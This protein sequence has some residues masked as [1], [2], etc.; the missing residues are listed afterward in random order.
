MTRHRLTALV[1]AA[2]VV[3]VALGFVLVLS[4]DR[5]TAPFGDSDEGVNAAVWATDSRAVRELGITESRLGGLRVDGTLYASH[6]PLIVV[7]TALA[8]TVFG[9]HEWASRMPAWAGT[10]GALVAMFALLRRT[11]VDAVASAGAVAAVAVT[12]MCFTYGSMLDTPVT[13]LPFG[14]LL[15]VAWQ[16]SWT[17]MSSSDGGGPAPWM[18]P[19]LAAF[20]AVLAGWQALFLVGLAC[21]SLAI[22]GWR[23]TRSIR[24]AVPYALGGVLGAALSFGWA[25]W[26]Y[27]DFEVMIDKFSGRS[28]GSAADTTLLGM[29]GFQVP[30]LLQL[31]ALGIIGLGGCIAALWSDRLRP[32]AAMSLAA[33]FGYAVV[34]HAAAAGHQYWNYWVLLPT[35]V[36]FAHLFSRLPR[37][38]EQAAPA[39][40][41]VA[42]VLMGVYN[43]LLAPNEAV[44]AIRAGHRPAEE[45]LA[46]NVPESARV[47]YVGEP[48][49]PDAWVGYYTGGTPVLLTSVQQLDQVATGDPHAPVVVLAA[50]TDGS[51]E[52]C[53]AA[54]DAW[55]GEPPPQLTTAAELQEVLRD[56]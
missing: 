34:F 16:R 49:R 22:W 1:P 41:S 26:V 46:S 10:I 8:E 19:A 12:P 42:C 43:V 17:A 25:L 52:L 54:L 29:V 47:Y 50:C 5:V 31:L 44:D 4:W 11:G 28:A 27:G 53:A 37:S 40:V 7:E 21:A 23:R 56:R 24:A 13:A 51:G 39:V 14:V 36:G 35:A 48:Y 38:L 3:A 55:D 20:A 33:V 45:L 2:V 9:E 18:W 15:L 32:L 30:W 6:P